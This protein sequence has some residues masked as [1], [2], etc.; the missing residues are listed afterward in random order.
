MYQFYIDT[1]NFIQATDSSEVWAEKKT[2]KDSFNG[3]KHEV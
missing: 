1:I 3:L 2:I